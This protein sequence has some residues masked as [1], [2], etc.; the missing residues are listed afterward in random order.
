[1]SGTRKEVSDATVAI[2]R[3]DRPSPHVFMEALVVEFDLETLE[4]LS[5]TIG[6]GAVGNYSGGVYTPG[7]LTSDLLSFVRVFG[8]IN[9]TKFTA[10]I[11]AVA[12]ENKAHVVARPYITTRSG[13]AANLDIGRQRTYLTSQA[14]STGVFQSGSVQVPSGVVLRM[15]PTAL[16]GDRIRVDLHLEESQFIPSSGNIAAERDVN[17]A[18]SSMQ[19]ASGE[20]IVIGGLMLDRTTHN[21]TGVPLLWRLPLIGNLFRASDKSGKQ[22]QVVLFV[23]PRIWSP[24]IDAPLVRPGAFEM[25]EWLKLSRPEKGKEQAAPH[26]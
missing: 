6:D 13:E 17:V 15:T 26:P 10:F 22:Q 7:S 14:T 1:M 4:Q 19:V 12:G 20:T 9:P 11:Q 21:V 3:V 16:P 24:G 5:A 2:R 18:E 25:N 23:T 8:S